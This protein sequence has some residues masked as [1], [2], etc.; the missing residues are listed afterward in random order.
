[1]TFHKV[2][3][4]TKI[5]PKALPLRKAISI[6]AELIQAILELE[7][8]QGLLVPVPEGLNLDKYRRR[9]RA[10][11]SRVIEP[12]SSCRYRVSVAVNGEILV[13]CYE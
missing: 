5:A 9:I 1:M 7:P 8:P 13:G 3:D 12:S 11:V 10:M 2:A 6:Y 4:A